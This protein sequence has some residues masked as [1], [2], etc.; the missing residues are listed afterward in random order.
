MSFWSHLFDS[1]LKQ[2]KDIERLRVDFEAVYDGSDALHRMVREQE[3]HIARLELTVE[4]LVSVLRARHVMSGDELALAIQR[5]DLA[6][7]RE[8]GRIALEPDTSAPE[9]PACA[10]PVNPTRRQCVYC[11]TRFEPGDLV[12]AKGVRMLGCASCASTV[13]ERTTWFTERGVVCDSCYHGA[14]DRP[15]ALSLAEDAAGA[16]SHTGGGELSES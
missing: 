8:D 6:D 2:R 13:P 16:L 7:G 5:I 4:G 12:Q 1:E 3:L 15:G 10:R 11:D 14:G 9:C